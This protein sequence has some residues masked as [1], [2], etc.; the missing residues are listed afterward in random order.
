MGKKK[1]QQN[2][3]NYRGD[4]MF[5]PES[6]NR[7]LSH[8]NL[9]VTSD[10]FDENGAPLTPDYDY[11]YPKE[12]RQED[13]PARFN[14]A[15]AP[16]YEDFTSAKHAIEK[17]KKKKNA[18][19]IK[20][21]YDLTDVPE[22][23]D[24]FIRK[25]ATKDAHMEKPEE[26]S[27]P[28]PQTYE[29]PVEEPEEDI[30]EEDIDYDPMERIYGDINT[31]D[32]TLEVTSDEHAPEVSDQLNRERYNE[33]MEI[34]S[35]NIRYIEPLH[36]L[37]I[38]DYIAPSSY[39]R[40]IATPDECYC[41]END[42]A[43]LLL[44][45]NGRFSETKYSN[46]VRLM[47]AFLIVRKH[48]CAIFTEEEFYAKFSSIKYYDK[49]TFRFFG[50]YNRET[51][52]VY[53][54]V[55]SKRSLE[56]LD[57]FVYDCKMHIMQRYP[58]FFTGEFNGYTCSDM[59]RQKAAKALVYIN[60]VKDMGRREYFDTETEDYVLAYKDTTVASLDDDSTLAFNHNDTMLEMIL[61]HG[62]TEFD[63]H[64]E[65]DQDVV[66][67]RMN[68]LDY[69]G[70][71]ENVEEVIDVFLEHIDQEDADAEEDTTD[72][73]TYEEEDV[74]ELLDQINDAIE[75]DDPEEEE[76]ESNLLHAQTHPAESNLRSLYQVYVEQ[77]R[78]INTSS[79]VFVPP[80][81]E[82]FLEDEEFR[83]SVSSIDLNVNVSKTEIVEETKPVETVTKPKPTQT[84]SVTASTMKDALIKSG[85]MNTGASK[86]EE[87]DDDE[88]WTIPV[89]RN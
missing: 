7:A 26:P 4:Y 72:A 10:D 40:P 64:P 14:P 23:I 25:M 13:Q 30:E 75:D 66:D 53:G 79:T 88:K 5:D 43:R 42:L 17:P 29:M 69:V 77:K 89:R 2:S 84:E 58:Y 61:R 54:Y 74:S 52:Y 34:M 63:D 65:E 18:V 59:E 85:F 76:R 12:T 56:A 87:P 16:S 78:A 35:L 60:L 70:I 32:E 1:K 27:Y 28:Y 22:D 3:S 8:S 11:P 33:L 73:E 81:F 83:K 24:E 6:I 20:K 55:I 31:P 68:V 15:N 82:E 46:L 39:T 45:E 67:D 38:D 19:T 57:K 80:T 48:P 44:D 62:K 9:D 71:L 47:K 50:D 49:N 21:D 36:R 86:K 41:D 51:P 37:V